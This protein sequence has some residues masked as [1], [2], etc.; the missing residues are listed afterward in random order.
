VVLTAVLLVKDFKI[1]AASGLEGE[2]G[3]LFG[4]KR[5]RDTSSVVICPA[6]ACGTR[7]L[8]GLRDQALALPCLVFTKP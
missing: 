3:T 8:V 1:V 4:G 6:E 5:D 7:R 2:F